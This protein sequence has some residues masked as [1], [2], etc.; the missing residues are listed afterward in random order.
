MGSC[1]LGAALGEPEDICDIFCRVE[2]LPRSVM[3]P[4]LRTKKDWHTLPEYLKHLEALPI[5]PNVA[6]FVGH[7]NLRMHVMADRSVTPGERPTPS[8]MHRMEQ[9]SKTPRM[10]IWGYPS[11]RCLGTNSTA[12]VPKAAPLRFAS[13]REYR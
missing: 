6:S 12:L 8:E 10:D 5:G 9:M 4:M 11:R 7:S 13:W 1:S 3:L 2:G